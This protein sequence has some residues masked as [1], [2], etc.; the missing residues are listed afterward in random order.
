MYYY[1]DTELNVPDVADVLNCNQTYVYRAIRNY[2]IKALKSTPTK[3]KFEDVVDY[4][5]STL[6]PSW[7]TYYKATQVS[8]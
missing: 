4:V 8:L 5:N 1:D 2:R 3:V 7:K 6:P